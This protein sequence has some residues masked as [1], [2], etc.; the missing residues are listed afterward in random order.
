MVGYYSMSE[1]L[2]SPRKLE[3]HQLRTE[4]SECGTVLAMR[5]KD[6]EEQV[7]VTLVQAIQV[8][9]G[10]HITNYMKERVYFVFC[11]HQVIH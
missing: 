2:A 3:T 8:L 5:G 7:L 1:R 6:T 4:L 10:L 11:I 9:Y